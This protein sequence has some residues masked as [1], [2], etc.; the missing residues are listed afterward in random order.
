MREVTFPKP[1]PPNSSSDGALSN[2]HGT[3]R[4]APLSFKEL[5]ERFHD[6]YPSFITELRKKRDHYL[7]FLKYPDAIRRSLSTTNAVEAVNGQLEI[8]RR[9]SG[10]YFQSDD[11]LKLNLGITITALENGRWSKVMGKI[12]ECLHQLNAMFQIRFKPRRNSCA[13]TQHY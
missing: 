11:V 8:I 2:V 7:R 1:T 10:G 5:C 12:E 4:S 13:Q 6:S 3:N 9:N